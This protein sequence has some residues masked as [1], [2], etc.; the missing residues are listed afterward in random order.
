M[1]KCFV[2]MPF[3]SAFNDVYEAIK[4]AV[5]SVFANDDCSCIR[6]DEIITAGRITDDLIQEL[7]EAF[8]CIA[9][10][11]G[12][13]PNVMWEVG[14]AM[15]LEKPTIFINQSLKSMPFDI[16][17]MRGLEYSMENLEET[18]RKPL[19]K[20]LK[21]T[22]LRY[23]SKHAENLKAQSEVKKGDLIIHDH[24]SDTYL[25]KMFSGAKESIRIQQIWMTNFM[26][27]RSTLVDCAKNCNIRILFLDP[28][29][30]Q[31]KYRSNDLGYHDKK[32]LSD[33][34]NYV[35]RMIESNLIAFGKLKK[36]AKVNG[37]I[38]IRFYDTTPVVSIYGYDEKNIIGIYWRKKGAVSA[39]QMEVDLETE[40]GK[41]SQAHFEDIWDSAKPLGN[42]F[43][44]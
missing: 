8:I 40:L 32:G 41:V 24:L 34:S 20:S 27:V 43:S 22:Y 15:A 6:L 26:S 12:N 3:D 29:S 18:L 9:D 28:H 5:N 25:R 13:N 35:R 2:M 39:P 1:I 21:N 11:T 23:L 42:L 10:I 7:Q 44:K 31:T 30:I 33:D 14:Y 37:N 16:K 36:D 17:D 19:E 38:D 4:Q